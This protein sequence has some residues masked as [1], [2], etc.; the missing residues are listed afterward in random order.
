[1]RKPLPIV[2]LV[3][4]GLSVLIYL[5]PGAG[6][7]VYDRDAILAGEWWR[8]IT[9][10]W[11]HFSA[12]HFLYDTTAFGFAGAMVER[13]GHRNFGWLCA[14]AMVVISG[15]MFVF[16]PRLEVCGGL[17]GLA[18]AAVVFLTL[19]GLEEQ[20]AWRWICGLA[21]VLCLAKLLVELTTRHFVLL[22]APGG[23]MPVPANHIAGALTAAGVYVWPKIEAG[24]VGMARRVSCWSSGCAG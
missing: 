1:M 2:T 20:G 11:V 24:A 7:L 12:Q 16:E 21:L 22:Q 6:R 3:V 10:H 23:L 9:G 4:V 19:H 18:T 13:R 5:L 8:V 15:S 14:I 17:S